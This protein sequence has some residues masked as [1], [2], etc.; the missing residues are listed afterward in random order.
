LVDAFPEVP[1]IDGPRLDVP[2]LRVAFTDD[3]AG[4]EAAAGDKAR[5]D[6]VP[7]LPPA[8]LAG[9]LA[10]EVLGLD[11]PIGRFAKRFS[12][13]GERLTPGALKFGSLGSPTQKPW[14]LG[15]KNP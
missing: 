8:D 7:V 4:L 5:K 15:G 3:L 12:S 2:A 13:S 11:V 14:Y 9:V 1:G 6:R 10:A